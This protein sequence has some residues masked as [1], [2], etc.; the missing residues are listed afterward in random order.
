MSADRRHQRKPIFDVHPVTSASIEVFYVDTSLM[1][2][3][4]GRCWLVLQVRRRGFAPE[5]TAHGQLPTT[6]SAYRDA[7]KSGQPCHSLPD[8]FGNAADRSSRIKIK[9]KVST[10]YQPKKKR[11]SNSS[12]QN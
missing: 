6:Y 10:R 4:G 1:S 7:M 11:K 5:G 3:G 12:A 9:G 2:F 8:W